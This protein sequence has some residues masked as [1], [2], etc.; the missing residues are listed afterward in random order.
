MPTMRYA[1]IA[2]A[3]QLPMLVSA[4][5]AADPPKAAGPSVA[6]KMA[7]EAGEIQPIL[8]RSRIVSK[9]TP[10]RFKG[11]SGEI[12]VNGSPM[13]LAA[14]FSPSKDDPMNY[15]TIGLDI[16]RNGTVDDDEFVRT[17][18]KACSFKF[19]G[20]DGREYQLF[21]CCPEPSLF[22]NVGNGKAVG[23][24]MVKPFAGT[25]YPNYCM[26]GAVAGQSVRLID[27]NADGVFTQDGKDGIAIG[28]G[29]YALPLYRTHMIAGKHYQIEVASDGSSIAFAPA[30]NLKVGLVESPLLTAAAKAIVIADE[31]NGRA[32]DLVSA[33]KAG[34]PEGTYSFCYTV[35]TSGDASLSGIPATA[36]KF[37]GNAGTP[38]YPITADRINVLSLGPPFRLSYQACKYDSSIIVTPAPGIE[39][40]SSGSDVNITRYVGIGMVGSGNEYYALTYTKG[41][42]PPSVSLYNGGKLLSQESMKF[43]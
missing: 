42:T 1:I 32:Y 39:I 22:S 9:G 13:K 34:I 2:L 29:N 6:A 26:K 11:D 40:A 24:L 27:E 7:F 25:Y 21:V 16:N 38:Q 20:T 3:A 23:K 8:T 28:N 19:K 12:N 41:K 4:A 15:I 31:A 33:G 30:G 18:D 36:G 37:P 10:F 5:M 17:K 14:K 35:I 43:G